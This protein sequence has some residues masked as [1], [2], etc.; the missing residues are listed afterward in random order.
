MSK[1]W[2]FESVVEI[3]IIF[4]KGATYGKWQNSLGKTETIVHRV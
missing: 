2:Q 4:V 1:S 3:M